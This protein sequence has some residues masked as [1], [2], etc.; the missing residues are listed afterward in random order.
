[1][2]RELGADVVIDYKTQRFED[3][4]ADLEMV[5]DLIDG[6][7]RER[8]WGLLKKIGVLVSTLTEPS[9]ERHDQR[10]QIRGSS[11]HLH[12]WCTSLR[13][14]ESD[15]VDEELAGLAEVLDLAGPLEKVD[16]NLNGVLE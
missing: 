11:R 7:T 4:V 15:L 1:M 10:R 2:A 5:F 8:S 3:H 12:S 9:A 14:H 6:E 13:D 16:G